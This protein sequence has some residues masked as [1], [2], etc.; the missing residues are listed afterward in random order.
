LLGLVVGI[1]VSRIISFPISFII[2][3]EERFFIQIFL[4]GLLGYLGV[5]LGVKGQKDFIS[6]I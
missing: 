5:I 4:S 1:L 2:P 6:T 3:D